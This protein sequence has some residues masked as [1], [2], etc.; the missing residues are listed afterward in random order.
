VITL[1]AVLIAVPAVLFAYAYVGYPLLLWVGSRARASHVAVVEAG[2]WPAITIVV[3]AYNAET[4]IRRTLDHILAADYPADRRQLLVVSDASTDHTDEIVREEYA[5]RGVEMHRAPRRGGKAAAENFVAPHIRHGIVVNTDAT[6]VIPAASLKRLLRPFADP[7]VG[8][9]SGRDV[10]VPTSPSEST[11]GETSYS[12]YEMWV[13]SLEAR[14]GWIVGATGSLYAVRRELHDSRLAPHLS[15]DFASTLLAYERGL[16]SVA[17]DDAVCIV[18][19]TPS[20]RA[21]F[22]RKA[23]TMV[24]GLDT[25]WHFR[26]LLNPARHGWFAVMMLSHKVARWLVYALAPLALVSLALLSAEWN[27]AAWALGL[28]ALFALAGWLGVIWPPTRRAPTMLAMCGYVIAMG[29]AG[30]VAWLRFMRGT[31]SV[32]WEPTK[33]VR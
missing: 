15:R 20:L 28:L 31:H 5:S 13:R 14:F 10:S 33:R 7:G 18:G 19:Q 2:E 12:N 29:A 11:K 1:A 22:R 26:R 27:P 25:L 6:I 24:L 23:R 8:V 21:E 3:P 4:S 30:F 32:V 9:V 16:R 17:A